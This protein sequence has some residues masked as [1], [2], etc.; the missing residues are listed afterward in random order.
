MN[1]KK[2]SK[3]IW[4]QTATKKI[5]KC[6][7]GIYVGT[8]SLCTKIFCSYDTWLDRDYFRFGKTAPKQFAVVYYADNKKRL[9]P[10]DDLEII[11]EEGATK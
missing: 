7:K 9:V 11:N 8:T 4:K 10:I 5:E 1:M 3:I 2:K 6:F